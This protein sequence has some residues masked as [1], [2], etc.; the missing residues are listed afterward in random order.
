MTIGIVV[1]IFDNDIW[2]IILYLCLFYLKT[3]D[4]LFFNKFIMMLSRF[5]YCVSRSN[6]SNI[7]GGC[8]DIFR[9]LLI[10][11]LLTF[12]VIKVVVVLP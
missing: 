7:Y 11:N 1:Y 5:Y 9:E 12:I 4:F 2:N 6:W 8:P 3:D 10:S